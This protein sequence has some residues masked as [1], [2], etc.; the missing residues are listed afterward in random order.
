MSLRDSLIFDT[1][2]LT[3]F[4]LREAAGGSLGSD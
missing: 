3:Y 4:S 1:A 2:A